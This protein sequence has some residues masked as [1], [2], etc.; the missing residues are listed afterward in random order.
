M[1]YRGIARRGTLVFGGVSFSTPPAI[2]QMSSEEASILQTLYGDQVSLELLEPEPMSGA[3]TA[4][5]DES[6]RERPRRTRRAP[7][8]DDSEAIVLG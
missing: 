4:L 5:K 7:A 3:Q 8:D 1:R 2:Y 6:E